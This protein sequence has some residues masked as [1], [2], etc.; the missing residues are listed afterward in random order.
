MGRPGKSSI[1]FVLT[2]TIG[3][4]LATALAIG[5]FVM[6]KPSAER[7]G[8]SS[9]AEGWQQVGEILARIQ[10]PTFPNR[11]F[12]ITDYG[13]VGDGRKVCTEAFAEAID[14]CNAAGGGRVIVPPGRYFTGPIHLKSN[15]NLHVKDGATISFSTK[16]NDYMPVVFSRWEGMECMNYSP[17]I[18]AYKQTNVAVTGKGTLDGQADTEHWWPW[19]GNTEFGYKVGDP[20]QNAYRDRLFAMAMHNIPPEK[21]LMGDGSYLR[22]SF[23]QTHS[24][25]NVLIEGVTIKRTPSW[26]IHPVLCE[27]LTVRG[28]TVD[29]YGP[30]SDGCDPESCRD[31]LIEDCVFIGRDDC[32]ALKSGRNHE[33]RR[34]DVP[35]EN[36]VIRNCTFKSGHGAIVIG[37]EVSGGARN[38][39]VENCT[40]EGPDLDHGLRVKTNSVR[41][42]VVEN[43]Y[44]RNV[45][46]D[47]IRHA[48]LLIDFYYEEGDTGQ[49]PP[50]VRNIR[51]DDV[52]CRKSKFAIFA[53][54]YARAP[55]RD[56]YLNNCN[57][58][59][60]DNGNVIQDVDG[61]YASNVT[62]GGQPFESKTSYVREVRPVALTAGNSTS[63][64]L[65]SFL[66]N[67]EEQGADGWTPSKGG[68]TVIDDGDGNMAYT[69]TDPGESRAEAGD[70]NW[71]D[72]RVDVR[73]NVKSFNGEN[74]VMVCGRYTDGNNYY[75]ASIY[76]SPSGEVVELHKKHDKQ[77]LRI[78]RVPISLRENSWHRLGLGMKGD[79]IRVYFDETPLIMVSDQTF[80]SG[81]IG[82]IT[83]RSQA[84]FDDVTVTPLVEEKKFP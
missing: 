9:T 10:A 3:L 6:F 13:A 7:P 32:I 56:V 55:I 62:I 67:F 4:I 39:F 65:P 76:N 68:W 83:V 23:I 45:R 78:T 18:Y 20:D 19:K 82:L 31:V 66:A 80:S 63:A 15:V 52:T 69:S 36:V 2:L 37:S 30:N 61:L 41:G 16:P 43:V 42:G 74:R 58:A 81:K 50:A 24:C 28:V 75:A 72:Y 49:H 79:N 47:E 38:I 48:A 29:C 25:R 33:G 71:N 44:L 8:G 14:A 22:P 21:R 17:M 64:T 46:I 73:V 57:I 12:R 11:E 84:M 53:R 59:E 51:L 35:V 27:N 60:A 40:L 26:A 77:T 5:G 1:S 70:P 34:L 54:G